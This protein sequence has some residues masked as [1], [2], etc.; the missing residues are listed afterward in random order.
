MTGAGRRFGPTTAVLVLALLGALLSAPAP[1]TAQAPTEPLHC[2]ADDVGDGQ[3]LD[4]LEVCASLTDSLV[5]HLHLDRAP[6]PDVYN[7]LGVQLFSPQ[8]SR[9]QQGTVTEPQDRFV[10]QIAAS[11]R[12]GAFHPR[13]E[14]GLTC[15][16]SWALL[17]GGRTVAMTLAS[18]A[19]IGAPES[20]ALNAFAFT[21]DEDTANQ[22]DC[23]LDCGFTGQM[24]LPPTPNDDVA[25]ALPITVGG[26]APV[27]VRGATIEPGEA[28]H[29]GRGFR[30]AWYRLTVPSDQQVTATTAGADFD[31][32][33]TVHT[34]TD[35]TDLDVVAT[36]D[37]DDGVLTSS[38]TWTA[39]AGT[40]YLIAV[41]GYLGE[42]GTGTLQVL[43]AGQPITSIAATTRSGSVLG[44]LPQAE[45]S[46]VMYDQSSEGRSPVDVA[47]AFAQSTFPDGAATV[48]IARSDTFPDALASGLLQA[49]GP[50]LLVPPTGPLPQAVAE[51]VTR[52]APD[53]VRI[54]GGTAAVDQAVEDQLRADGLSVT[55]LGGATRF[56]TAARIADGAPTGGT[57]LVVRG[58]DAGST[59]P[60]QAFADSLA[61]GG[62]AAANGWP[63]L[64]TAQASL[65]GP[66][67]DRLAQLAPAHV[68]V[69][70]GPAAVS[71]A[72]AAELATFA[73][74]R[75]IAGPTRID[76]AIAVAEELTR[77]RGAGTDAVTVVDGQR[78][79]GWV[80]G[81]VAASRTAIDGAPVLLGTR[82][83]LPAAT[84]GW[85]RSN[86]L[87][88]TYEDDHVVV[89]CVVAYRSCEEAR[90]VA[91]LSATPLFSF[92]PPGGTFLE[93]PTDV[94]IS[95]DP[96]EL[97][98]G[99]TVQVRSRCHD[100]SGGG[101]ESSVGVT[102]DANG[103]AAVTLAPTDEQDCFVH[104]FASL[105]D[106]SSASMATSYLMPF[107]GAPTEVSV[108][109][110]TVT[111]STD[112]GRLVTPV[113]VDV[114][115][116]C[117]GDGVGATER[118]IGDD[119]AP[120]K[121]LEE[122][123]V[124]Y[125]I[126]FA[127]Q[128]VPGETC[129]LNL[130]V[131][132]E[133]VEVQWEV[134]DFLTQGSQDVNGATEVQRPVVAAGHGSDV[135]FTLA[136]DAAVGFLLELRV[137][138]RLSTTAPTAADLPSTGEGVLVG[139]GF[140]DDV[141]VTCDDGSSAGAST[142]LVVAD[143]ATCTT[144]SPDP[145]VVWQAGRPVEALVNPSFVAD[146]A[147]GPVRVVVAEAHRQ[148]T[149]V[150]MTVAL[151]AGGPLSRPLVLPVRSSCPDR[152][153]QDG[154]AV[155]LHPAGA[156]A[157]DEPLT[158]FVA[159]GCEV[160]LDAPSGWQPRWT[161]V[162]ERYTDGG[163]VQEEV[164]S[165]TGLSV[166]VPEV[167]TD[168][169]LRLRWTLDVSGTPP[170]VAVQ[171][172]SRVSVRLVYGPYPF[173][174]SCDDGTR[175]DSYAFDPV[176]VPPGTRCTVSPTDS[177]PGEQLI[178]ARWNQPFTFADEL[179]FTATA[180]GGPITIMMTSPDA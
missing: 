97:A 153:V 163:P 123:S 167:A 26:T 151:D 34:G 9:V 137:V 106:G 165:G 10:G 95:V 140:E 77:T 11:Y 174:M 120:Y 38:T 171:P 100:L 75:R 25:D 146:E 107:E 13:V 65:P 66:T 27:D 152:T 124:G 51:E 141:Q 47:L 67:R 128:V 119:P 157:Y 54:L 17:D 63:I 126:G 94:R 113:A 148:Q 99:Q 143:G 22:N 92:D 178:L 79:D 96:P 86:L 42:I 3:P 117:S 5:V 14:S 23:L 78:P 57:V 130:G 133:T 48:T 129:R 33:L 101:G 44:D 85:M 73:P 162:D 138:L 90:R 170:T 30:S 37:D 125:S 112:P 40:A 50:M 147:R 69:V 15:S 121:S 134:A 169:T 160:V 150:A 52:L 104:V 31:T 32:V 58:D 135:V 149:T 16:P 98:A 118:V 91:G 177:A 41:S 122:V 62:L 81:L 55:R 43:P 46:L 84:A 176:S 18:T 142:N 110:L 83:A 87:D 56:D 35:V 131:P 36:A 108:R 76:T 45:G 145:V 72:V 109:Q 24:H 74:V 39:R 89:A 180:D 111:T 4:L 173:A 19:C 2:V 102:L 82:D 53:Q 166:T 127:R 49:D 175:T 28:P 93:E 80:G 71:D 116:T 136:P 20:L 168:G 7:D 70:G 1:A 158:H 60:S 179:S 21:Y 164:A 88:I 154:W 64:L 114:T 172:G 159:A 68:V 61:A 6:D 59:D 12:D 156:N 144:T 161:L 105:E 115:G 139:I 29:A 103:E 155:H 132:P 8:P